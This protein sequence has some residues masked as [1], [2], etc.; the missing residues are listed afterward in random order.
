MTVDDYVQRQIA[1]KIFN[2]KIE[3]RP[4]KTGDYIIF[5]HHIS[6]AIYWAANFGCDRFRIM[7]D[8]VSKLLHTSI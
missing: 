1:Q 5:K 3:A 8:I 6:F 4:V 7:P 2:L